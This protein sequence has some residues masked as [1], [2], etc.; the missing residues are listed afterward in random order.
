MY[1]II[2]KDEGQLRK[3]SETQHA[4]ILVEDSKCPIS[5][6]VI[7]SAESIESIGTKGNRVYYVLAGKVTVDSTLL[8]KDDCLIMSPN[9]SCVL[10]GTCKLLE[11][12]Y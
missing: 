5:V 2:R 7:E 12:S 9:D 8:H 1:T 10:S 3:L 6:R 11:I 4:S